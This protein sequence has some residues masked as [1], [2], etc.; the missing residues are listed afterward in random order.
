MISVYISRKL[1]K[2]NKADLSLRKLV[3]TVINE[4]SPKFKLPKRPLDI[5]LF[6]EPSW[7]EY[8]PANKVGTYSY[9]ANSS[10]GTNRALIGLRQLYLTK[11]LGGDKEKIRSLLQHELIHIHIDPNSNN[12][13]HGY[14]FRKHAKKIGLVSDKNAFNKVNDKHWKLLIKGKQ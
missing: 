4:E 2:P 1:G 10:L 9:K 12:P 14:E 5:T 6:D 8:F 3:E 13:I 7:L 11:V